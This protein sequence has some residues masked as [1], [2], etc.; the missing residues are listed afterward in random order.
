[1]S[2]KS[3]LLY[4]CIFFTV[5]CSQ[6]Y[7]GFVAVAQANSDTTMMEFYRLPSPDVFPE[8][9][10]ELD[11]H[12]I[13]EKDSSRLPALFF[14]SEVFRIHPDK[15][16]KWCASFIDSEMP[17]RFDVGLAIKIS[18]IPVATECITNSLGLTEEE[19]Q[20]LID[21]KQY[22]PTKDAHSTAALLDILWGMFVASGDTRYVHRVIDA[23]GEELDGGM[24]VASKA[25]EWSLGSMA[26]QH[27][28][29]KDTLLE[30]SKTDT[31]A[32]KQAIDTILSNLESD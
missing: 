13:F 32:R 26:S 6:T 1:M 14:M 18:N 24:N 28:L 8:L 5:I 19:Q 9:V 12:G 22:D 10:K 11:G 21:V 4:A 30:R 3:Y 29:V 25:A 23:L 15:A 17:L 16:Q 2:L 31:G 27:Q 20:F 7:F